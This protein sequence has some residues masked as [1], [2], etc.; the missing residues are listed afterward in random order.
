MYQNIIQSHYKK[1]QYFWIVSIIILAI[2]ISLTLIIWLPSNFVRLQSF[3]IGEQFEAYHAALNIQRFG[4]FLSAGI[5]DEATN[6]SLLAHPYLYTHHANN[7]IYFSYLMMSFGI[8][9]L[10]LQNALSILGSAGGL[11]I[12]LFA[13]RS[14]TGS[15]VFAILSMGMLALDYEL[16]R[17][18]S[19]NIHRGLTYLSIFTAFLVFNEASIKNY[20]NYKLNIGSLLTCILLIGTDYLYFT[21]AFWF[22]IAWAC[23]L[24]YKLFIN[25]I[26]VIAL[27]II[28]FIITFLLRQAQVAYAMGWDTFSEE[29]I[30]QALNRLHLEFLYSGDWVKKTNDF[31]ATHKILNTGFTHKVNLIDVIYRFATESGLALLN[32]ILG[33]SLPSLVAQILTV[34][35]MA[36]ALGSITI[37]EL[38]GWQYYARRVSLLVLVA[39]I[40]VMAAGFVSNLGGSS[41]FAKVIGY[42]FSIIFLI[43]IYFFDIW[44]KKRNQ[45]SSENIKVILLGICILCGCFGVILTLP[46]YFLGWYRQFQLDSICAAIWIGVTLTPFL[47]SAELGSKKYFIISILFVI[48]LISLS[49]Q[50]LPLP[51]VGG[52]HTLALIKLRGEPT[53]SNFTPASTASYTHAFSG[54]I[55]PNGARLLLSGQTVTADDYWMLLERDSNSNPIYIKPHYFVFYKGLVIFK[56]DWSVLDEFLPIEEGNDYAIYSIPSQR[57]FVKK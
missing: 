6:P 28:V 9:S 47:S 45:Q 49:T 17:D 20:Y 30:F 8:D 22:I 43:C 41:Y 48:K 35:L 29:F 18:W 50:L 21:F 10:P 25:R 42:L 19:V 55:K 56:D 37:L 23:T 1:F 12:A 15:F 5:Q 24:K 39:L 26:R 36:L 32:N 11:A 13:L 53:V 51:P 31:Y 33:M 52:D 46:G 4:W 38:I 44:P 54:F 3:A 57:V 27:I 7:G 14:L 34:K 40:G 2:Y 16:I